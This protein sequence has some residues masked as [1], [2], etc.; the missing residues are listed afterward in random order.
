MLA[1]SLFSDRRGVWAFGQGVVAVTAGV[2][3]HLPMF[4]MGGMT[5]YRLAGMAMGGDMVLGMALIV[6]GV[7][8]AAYGLLPRNV[9]ARRAAA[10]AILIAL[11][12]AAALALVARFGKETRGRDLRVLDPDGHTF[13]ATGM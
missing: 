10:A 8:V 3:L 9:A 1:S 13:A 7:G 12:T 5:H 2:L 6:G 11:P 4:W